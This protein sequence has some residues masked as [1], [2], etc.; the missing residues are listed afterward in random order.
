MCAKQA[1]PTEAQF[2]KKMAISF[3]NETWKFLDKPDRT[4]E[5]DAR[6]IH[7]AHASRLHWEFVGTQE[8]LAIGEWQ[9]SRVHAVL[10]QPDSALYHAKRSLAIAERN[11]LGPFHLACGHEAIA[12]AFSISHSGA[13]SE[14]I[15][16]ARKIALEITDPEGKETLDKDLFDIE[17]GY[18]SDA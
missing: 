12:R 9:V 15:A 7:L 11:S 13:A 18:R 14:H 5:E 8:N 2:H 6:M 4:P 1:T 3:F 17:A 10:G 16:I